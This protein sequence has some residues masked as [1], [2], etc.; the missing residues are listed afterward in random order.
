MA[1][2]HMSGTPTS[3]GMLMA[4][5]R[6]ARRKERRHVMFVLT[7]GAPDDDRELIKA[8]RAVEACNVTV[9]G[10]GIG[11][12]A[13]KRTF[14]KSI[15]LNRIEELPSLMISQLNAILLGDKKLQ[16]KTGAQA[17][18]AKAVA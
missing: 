5:S 6:L 12:G 1:N 2:V 17:E 18:K 10:I 11:T 4:H 8:V 16:A 13:V 3:A 9:V 15:V 7:D 14:S